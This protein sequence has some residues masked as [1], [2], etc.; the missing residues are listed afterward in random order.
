MKLAIM[1]PYIF[2][3]IGYFQLIQSVDKFVFYDDVDFIKGGWIN[4][5]KISTQQK[6]LLFTVPLDK[7]SSFKKI[8][9]I[10]LHP[11]IYKKWTVKFLKSIQQ[12]YSKSPFYNLVFPIIEEVFSGDHSSISDLTKASIKLTSKYLGIETEF[13]NSSQKYKNNHLKSQARVI[14]ICKLEDADT[15]INAI[16]GLELYNPLD[17]LNNGI[18]LRFLKPTMVPYNQFK[19][20]EFIPGLSIIDFIMNIDPS[21]VKD[22]LKMGSLISKD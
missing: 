7:A 3:Y 6:E 22:H 17:F 10:H 9:E 15:Y 4:R 2:P 11:V 8:N 13:V 18:E 16:G 12:S 5:N 1:Q 20:D 14:D 21:E 19:T